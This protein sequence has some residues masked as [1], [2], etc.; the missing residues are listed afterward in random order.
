VLKGGSHL[1]AENYCPRYSPR[2]A[3]P[4]VSFCGTALVIALTEAEFLS[5]LISEVYGGSG[6]G[7]GAAA[8]ALEPI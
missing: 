6:L 7:L 5:V 1:C 4:E 2:R 3:L 8:A